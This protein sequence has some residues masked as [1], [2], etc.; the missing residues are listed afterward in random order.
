MKT[1]H[2]AALA[3]VL[4]VG[5]AMPAYADWDN[6]GSVSVSHRSDRDTRTFDLGGPVDRINLRAEGSNIDCRAVNATFGNGRTRQ[7][8]SGRLYAGRVANVDLPGRDRNITRLAFNCRA[9]EFGGGTIRIAADIGSHRDEWRRNPNFGRVW[10]KVFNW[11]S[12]AVNN[13][14]YVG[15]VSFEGRRDR[16]TAFTGWRGRNVDSIALKPLDANAR[17]SRV[18]AVFGNGRARI[19]D[20]DSSDH[21]RQGQF[22]KVN[23]PGD[24][25]NL[26]SLNLQ[27]RATDA[28]RVT[29][30]IF[31][32]G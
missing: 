25:R 3:A 18:S 5:A 22:Y 6:I 27:C 28:R 32:G 9:Q 8:Y 1:T 23:L 11:G 31:T 19:L 14:R 29:V 4:C 30:Q 13:W 7:I 2:L 26:T 12:N 16:E 10:A 24:H 20:V 15:Q 17:C 21:M